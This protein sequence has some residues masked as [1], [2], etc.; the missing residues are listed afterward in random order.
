V[1]QAL[2]RAVQQ[3]EPATR[4]RIEHGA[5]LVGIELAVHVRGGD[6]AGAA[7]RRPGPASTK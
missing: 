4:R 1:T 3:R 2:G 6:A 7:A 5:L